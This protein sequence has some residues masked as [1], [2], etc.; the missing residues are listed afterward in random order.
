M[1]RPIRL[2][3]TTS[4]HFLLPWHP[5]LTARYPEGRGSLQPVRA[6]RLGSGHCRTQAVELHKA[7]GAP[8]QLPWLSDSLVATTSQAHPPPLSLAVLAPRICRLEPKEW[9]ERSTERRELRGE[10]DRPARNFPLA[11]KVI[12]QIQSMDSPTVSPR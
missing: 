10:A 9:D 8:A 6:V 4:P 3:S 11:L 12:L 5:V 1:T 2:R 7:E